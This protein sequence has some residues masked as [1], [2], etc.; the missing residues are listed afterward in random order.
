L[1]S[2]SRRCGTERRGQRR[3]SR[4]LNPSSNTLAFLPFPYVNST[5][6]APR[7]GMMATDTNGNLYVADLNN[8]RVLKFNDPFATDGLADDV[9][10]QTSF[11]NR[12]TPNPPTASSLRLQWEYGTTRRRVFRRRG[13][14]CP[15]KSLGCRQGNARVLRFPPG[16]KTAN[17]VLGQSSFTTPTSGSGLNQ[18]LET[19]AVRLHPATGELFVLVT[20]NGTRPP[21]VFWFSHRHSLTAKAPCARSAGRKPENQPSGLHFAR[22]LFLC[23][24][25]QQ[26]GLGGRWRQRSPP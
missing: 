1:L 10:G 19:T 6:E 22:G 14:R 20:V 21:A 15:G 9:W 3:Q 24:P 7:S 13:C 18:M 4:F 2:V 17:L 12:T 23:S 11:T 5:A 25:G 26:C 16:S 8:N